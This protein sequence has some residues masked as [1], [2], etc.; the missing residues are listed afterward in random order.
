ME[1]VV[2]VAIL[3]ILAGATVPVLIGGLERD[4]VTGAVAVLQDL[5]EAMTQMRADNQDW[6][7]RVS[8]LTKAITAS[9]FNVCWSSTYAPGKVSGWEGPYFYRVVPSTGMNI[10]I[11]IVKDSLYRSQ[12]V[13]NDGLLTIQVD[14]VSQEDAFGLNREVDND[15]DVAGR[16][17]GTVQWNATVT[18][19]QVTLFYYRPIRG[20]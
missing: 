8:H 7:G 19:G 5:T 10:G 2:V 11:G 6:P 4:R 13:G 14:N 15:G 16:T 1:V 12:L 9:D 18:D 3:L 17:T 20:C